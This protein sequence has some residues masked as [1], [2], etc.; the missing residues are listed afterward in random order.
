MVG[1]PGSRRM[2]ATYRPPLKSSRLMIPRGNEVIVIELRSPYLETMNGA[3]QATLDTLVVADYPALKELCWNYHLP[4]ITSD[5]ALCKYERNWRSVDKNSLT[6][7]E[8]ELIAHLTATVG[9]GVFLG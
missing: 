8:R 3:D 1:N 2:I 9:K 7:K 6:E 5:G 4:T